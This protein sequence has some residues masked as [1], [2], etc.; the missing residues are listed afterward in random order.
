MF[1]LCG[2]F[3][4]AEWIYPGR[5]S[6]LWPF[7]KQFKSFKRGPT[8]KLSHMLLGPVLQTTQM[9]FQGS[10]FYIKCFGFFF[11]RPFPSLS[12]SVVA[13]AFCTLFCSIVAHCALCDSH[14]ETR[15]GCFSTSRL[16]FCLHLCEILARYSDFHI[17]Q[18]KCNG[19]FFFLHAPFPLPLFI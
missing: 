15:L 13:A 8:S 9:S 6:L 14:N 3:D 11:N 1:F 2:Y 17:T 16:N 5:W 19:I 18:W 7:M 4:L 12:G 10:R